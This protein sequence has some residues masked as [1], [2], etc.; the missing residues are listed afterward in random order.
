VKSFPGAQVKAAFVKGQPLLEQN[1]YKVHASHRDGPG[2]VEVHARDTDILYVLRGTATLVTGGTVVDGKST[3]PFEV[4]GASVKGG[5]TQTLAP[6]DVVV[7]PRGVPHWFKEV[8]GPLDYFA[9][10]VQ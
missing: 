4:R 7:V 5:Q 8:P 6:G 2:Q 3:E 10:K 9:V 1:N